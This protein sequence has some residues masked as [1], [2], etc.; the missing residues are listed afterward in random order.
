MLSEG[1][2]ISV[3]PILPFKLSRQFGL[4]EHGIGLFF[5]HFTL[6]VVVVSVALLWVPHK[7]NKLLFI[8]PSYFV[9][10]AG[11]FMTGPSKLLG[12]PNNLDLMKVGMCVA[13]VGRAPIYS[14]A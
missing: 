12:L 5:F 4:D 14:L 8:L 6:V 11:A 13:G 2:Y 7:T 10:T 1:F 3:D 9:L